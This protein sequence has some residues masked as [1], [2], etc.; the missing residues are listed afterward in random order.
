MVFPVKNNDK[1]KVVV[2]NNMTISDLVS[3]YQQQSIAWIVL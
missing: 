3:F 1:R 2:T